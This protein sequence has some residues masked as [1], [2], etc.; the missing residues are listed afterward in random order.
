MVIT[1][2]KWS[3]ALTLLICWTG[4]A[5]AITNAMAQDSDGD[6]L[7]DV[8]EIDLGTDVNVAD[9]DGDGLE[10]G[11][12]YYFSQ[13]YSGRVV[14][15][16]NIQMISADLFTLDPLDPSDGNAD[17]DGDGLDNAFELLN[18]LDLLNAEDALYDADG[19]GLNNLAEFQLGTAV[20]NID[21]DGDGL[22]DSFELG[23]G[24]SPLSIDTDDDGF[25]D[26]FELNFHLAYNSKVVFYKN[27]QM[28]S[29]EI[30]TLNPLDS[31]DFN[32]DMDGDGISD[33]DEILVGLNP[34]DA[35]DALLDMDGDG[36]PNGWEIEQGLDPSQ[37]DIYSD[38]DGD[39]LSN[40]LEYQLGTSLFDVDTDN[41]GLQDDL[42]Y[43]FDLALNAKVV[44]YKSYQ[45]VTA[46]HFTLDPLDASDGFADQD[47]DGISNSLEI[48]NGLDLLDPAD[49]LLDT[50]G[51]GLSNIFEISNGF[52]W[53]DPN[54]VGMDSDGDGLTNIEEMQYGTSVDNADTDGDG[55]SDSYEILH[56][57]DPLVATNEE[58][59]A[60]VGTLAGQFSVNPSG[61]ASYSIPIDLPPGKNGMQ[62]SLALNYN[63]QSGNGDMGMGWGLVGIPS[64]ARCEADLVTDGF[65]GVVEISRDDLF[66]LDGQRLVLVSNHDYGADG[67]EYKVQ[68]GGVEKIVALSSQGYGPRRFKVYHTG[69]KISYFGNQDFGSDSM[70]W[71]TY[72]SGVSSNSNA[73][74]WYLNRQEDSFGNG[75][76][77]TYDNDTASSGAFKLEKITYSDYEVN[78]EWSTG[79]REDASAGYIAPYTIKVVDY[80]LEKVSWKSNGSEVISYNIDYQT[81]IDDKSYVSSISKCSN[82]KCLRPT[83]FH[84]EG[85]AEDYYPSDLYSN[86]MVDA[87][88]TDGTNDMG[89]RVADING[90]GL[91]DLIQLFIPANTLFYGGEPQHRVFLNNGGA[92]NSTP[93]AGYSNSLPNA[94]FTDGP[95]DMGTRLADLNGDGLLDLVQ[96]Y[97]SSTPNHYNSNPQRRVFL[98]NGSGFSAL[99]TTF[100]NSLPDTYFTDGSK[101]MGSRLVDVDGD[102]LVDLIQ[103]YNSQDANHYNASPQRRVY[104]NNGTTFESEPNPDYSVNLPDA[105]LTDGTKDMGTRLADFNGDGLVDIIQLYKSTNNYYGGEERR[106]VHLNNGSRFLDSDTDYSNSLPDA[107][108]TDGELDMGTRLTDLNGDGLVDL[109]QLYYSSTNNHYNGN[110]QHRAYLNNGR[111]FNTLDA[112]FSNTLPD[113][114][115]TAGSVDMG[116]RLADLNGDGLVDLVQLYH[117]TTANHYN[118][119]PQ[120]R[121]FLNTGRSFNT[122]DTLYSNKLPDAYFTDGKINM[123]TQLADIDGDGVLDIIQAYHSSDGYYGGD[124]RLRTV[125]KNVVSH[126][127]SS[128]SKNDLL[129]ST[130]AINYEKLTRSDHYERNIASD[131]PVISIIAPLDV[132]TSF[133]VDDGVGGAQETSYRYEDLQTHL[134]GLGALGFSVVGTTNHKTGITSSISYSH[135]WANRTIGM[136]N[137]SVSTTA[138]GVVLSHTR[139]DL[140]NRY[141]GVY[142]DR[143]LPYVPRSTS[144]RRDLNG[145]FIHTLTIESVL[146]S[147]GKLTDSYECHSAIDYS[148]GQKLG[149]TVACSVIGVGERNRHT[150]FDYFSDGYVEH[151]PGPIS[152]KT[153]TTTVPKTPPFQSPTVTQKVAYDYFTNLGG[154]LKSETVEPDIT[155]LQLKTEY[156]YYSDGLPYTRTVSG[157]EIAT[158]VT[159]YNYNDNG[160]LGSKTEGYGAQ[161]LITDYF[162][163][164]ARFPWLIT[165][166]RDPN[167]PSGYT[168]QAVFNDFGGAYQSVDKLGVT[169]TTYREWCINSVACDAGVG[170][171]YVETVVLGG[172][173]DTAV[174]YDQLAR[175]VRRT[176][177]GL[178]DGMPKAIIQTTRYSDR[179][180]IEFKSAPYYEGDPSDIG[181]S[182][183]YD[184][185]GRL[186]QTSD[187]EGRQSKVLYDGLKTT[188]TNAK[189]QTKQEIE[190]SLG[191][192]VEVIDSAQSSIHYEYDGLGKL[193]WMKDSAG[194]ETEMG[195]NRRGFKTK[196]RDP[197][198]GLLEYTYDGAGRLLTQKDNKGQISEMSYDNLGRKISRIDD[199]DGTPTVSSWVY[200]G[201]GQHIGRLASVNG[202]G[203]TETYDYD[204]D[205]RL[206][207]TTTSMEGDSY[208]STRNY[209]I[210]GRIASLTYPGAALQLDYEYDQ[211]TGLLLN[212][213]DAV[214]A[215]VYWEANHQN[216]AGTIEGFT[217]G[218]QIDVTV[219]HDSDTG[220][221][222]SIFA[223]H[224]ATSLVAQSYSYDDLGNLTD[225]HDTVNDVHDQYYYDN[226]NRLTSNDAFRNYAGG[227][228]AQQVLSY[229]ALGNINTKSDVEGGASYE[230]GG[231]GCS[232]SNQTCAH[233]VRKIGS[234]SFF[235]D[236]NGNMT[237]GWG[238]TIQ[239]NA[240]N[241]P[242]YIEKDGKTTAFSYGP[243]QRRYKR[244]DSGGSNPS[245][246]YYVQGLI[247]VVSGSVTKTKHHVGDFAIV[248]KQAGQAD[249]TRYLLKDQMGSLVAIADEGGNKVEDFNFDPWGK[250]R[251]VGGDFMDEIEYFSF[252]SSLV[253]NRGFTGHEHLDD[254]GLIHM[255]GR[256]FDPLIARFLSA[257]PI[258][259]APTNL[260][261]LNRYSYVLNNPLKYTDPSGFSWWS[262]AKKKVKKHWK[263]IRGAIKLVVAAAVFLVAV[264][265][266]P[267]QLA[268]IALVGS[269]ETFFAIA[270]GIAITLGEN[271]NNDLHNGRRERH[272]LEADRHSFEGAEIGVTIP[273]SGNSS[274]SSQ[275]YGNSYTATAGGSGAVSGPTVE[276]I[277]TNVW[278]WA[279][280]GVAVIGALTAGEA[281]LVVGGALAV[282]STE[283]GDGTLTEEQLRET[284]FDESVT[285]LYRAVTTSELVSIRVSRSFSLGGSGWEEKQF[286]LTPGDAIWYANAPLNRG[287]DLSIV[288][289]YVTDSTLRLAHPFSDA[290]HPAVSFNVKDFPVLNSDAKRFGI[291]EISR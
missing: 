272:G 79:G 274:G 140:S 15:Y 53:L 21:S 107:F 172:A 218:G 240:F 63:S 98:N 185:L 120:R 191:Q 148:S 93:D 232:N 257:D 170:E 260:Q 1:K 192:V 227:A 285:Q 118:N 69:G 164:N 104:L 88:F 23:I 38:S 203:L 137:E 168:S 29:A 263:E 22:S 113:T 194:N 119:T 99:D 166:T 165:A 196:M 41:D 208:T 19:D 259:Q 291:Y 128:I 193:V 139:N 2:R 154:A 223:M 200:F 12:E 254:V 153:T 94:Y 48:L 34:T 59:Y 224:G 81:S 142:S 230:Y 100:S 95:L 151:L 45:M 134:R 147:S 253:S 106:R 28:V 125:L 44:F 155:N 229:D 33:G 215:Q 252:S 202:N 70:H 39:G 213:S 37:S 150:H 96:L 231:A 186:I 222:D 89:T 115:F 220:L 18:G 279:R 271:G 270:G 74:I 189:L 207:Q 179:G 66:C 62:P 243:T 76:N 72:T 136:I 11:L 49:A 277:L 138:T 249:Q 181:V 163:N 42:E 275:N 159:Q 30:L 160:T 278:R 47:G 57:F 73:V 65:I 143:Y 26:E 123:G 58:D 13:A 237:S 290:G 77:Y 144:V 283:V 268:A 86:S 216:A 116:S 145:K 242:T 132:V 204:S 16:K 244:V 92:F 103:L 176:S 273:I 197:D 180:L 262:K 6:G 146:D 91:N 238:R 281:A 190:N 171:S 280:T 236:A 9:S 124:N 178:Q 32:L 54:D 110:A 269:A 199:R 209:D 261:S 264:I 177:T 61:S 97:Y 7:D 83:S 157:Y 130:I 40:V 211:V 152:A 133:E 122:L 234:K 10:D 221:V 127:I 126:K 250:R 205:S 187:A 109:L 212:V 85:G 67:S 27:Y 169:K 17:T 256:V 225:R 50:D 182:E 24:T 105:Y 251:H 102:G 210:F 129:D 247:E 266:N 52:D 117:P 31:S 158:N 149:A 265:P 114:Y 75:V 289:T 156:A 71:P 248:T 111:S 60:T 173:A 43:N 239:Y 35:A 84:I 90:D 56:G 245:T 51:D 112:G 14:F 141:Q 4:F 25:S 288:T 188:Y 184:A 267:F 198:K 241:K 201:S 282:S 162:Y 206:Y 286:W 80:L 174:I 258:I 82:G 101:D 78:F 175:E 36:I 131:Y 228:I 235:Y 46:D 183:L 217:L 255:N 135:D 214:N 226:L 161:N 108:F 3:L 20:N 287:M 64:I 195:Y 5:S 121:V 284:E 8:T 233:A 246:T 219:T 87:Y 68:T 276:S 55:M 167:T